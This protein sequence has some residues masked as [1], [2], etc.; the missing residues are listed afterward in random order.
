MEFGKIMKNFLLNLHEFSSSIGTGEAILSQEMH[1][2]RS[3]SQTNPQW[4]DE[5][6]TPYKNPPKDPQL[7]VQ[8]GYEHLFSC[9]TS[10]EAQ[11]SFTDPFSRSTTYAPLLRSFQPGFYSLRK[12]G[13]KEEHHPSTHT[14][15]GQWFLGKSPL[16]MKVKLE[17]LV[18]LWGLST[19]RRPPD[20]RTDARHNMTT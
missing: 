11:N 15:I 1:V 4:N 12:V 10:L 7:P 2:L 6:R 13:R 16:H 19:D 3:L 5:Y 9:Y 20:R 18:T 17:C 14:I 8:I